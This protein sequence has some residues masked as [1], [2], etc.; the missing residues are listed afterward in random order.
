VRAACADQ[1]YAGDSLAN[2]KPK[3]C[4]RSRFASEFNIHRATTSGPWRLSVS[5]N[6]PKRERGKKEKGEEQTREI[7]HIL[8][9]CPVEDVNRF[10][11]PT[12]IVHFW[13][14]SIPSHEL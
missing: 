14:V 6:S 12:R 1:L 11:V 10:L 9:A 5:T 7:H 13:F 8:A 3:P 2:L 4:K